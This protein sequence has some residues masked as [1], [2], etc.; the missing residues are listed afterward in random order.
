MKNISSILT[1]II[2]KLNQTDIDLELK[3]EKNLEKF[4]AFLNEQ[5]YILWVDNH[6]Q[7][8]PFFVNNRAKAFYGFPSN[9]LSSLG[10]KLYKKMLHPITFE[11]LKNIVFDFS[12]EK[13]FIHHETSYVKTKDGSYKYVYLASKALS[14]DANDKPAFILSLVF[15]IDSIIGSLINSK[16][17]PQDVNFEVANKHL[18][19]TLSPR[20]KEILHL[21]ADGN[22]NIKIAELLN[23]K[24]STVKSH[25]KTI[26]RKLNLNNS[27]ELVKYALYF[28]KVC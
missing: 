12:S 1:S 19:L 21:I 2:D 10:F 3:D 5:P 27:F 24:P 25:R 17:K 15:D 28:E 23:I 8:S 6:T 14:Y 18:Y 4:K 26:L 11:N 9:D 22:S 20:E 13:S 7:L 16:E